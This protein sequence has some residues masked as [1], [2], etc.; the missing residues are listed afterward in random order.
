MQIL[1]STWALQK[2]NLKHKHSSNYSSKGIRFLSDNTSN[3]ALGYGSVTVCGDGNFL[4]ATSFLSLL[5]HL[6]GILV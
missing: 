2:P 3:A 1:L 4:T 6:Q 5:S